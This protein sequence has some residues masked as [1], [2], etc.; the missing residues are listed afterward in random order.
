MRRLS[1]AGLAT[2]A[3]LG[4]GG[5][6]GGGGRPGDGTASGV[7]TT[8]ASA[9]GQASAWLTATPTTTAPARRRRPRPSPTAALLAHRLERDFALAGRASGAYV[10]DITS[11]AQLFAL[12]ATVRRPPASVNKL[13]TSV[14][15]LR[16][17][18]PGLRLHTTVLGTGHL[19]GGGVWRGNLYL[20]GGGD[21][22]L[23]DGGFNR[24][25]EDGYGPT[26]S[27]LA[28][29]LVRHGIRRV[30]GRLYGDASLFDARRGPPSS[31]FAPDI[32]DLGG[33][34][35]A[36]TFDHGSTGP[37][38][39]ASS[40]G[41]S[42][43]GT[44]SPGASAGGTHRRPAPPLSPGAFAA[45]QLAATLRD[46]HVQVTA[47]RRT[48][49]SPGRARRLAI[50]SSPPMS[51]MLRLMDVPSDDFFAEM[52]TKQLGVRIMGH[53]T[54]A[55]GAFVVRS[56]I[57]ADY[58]LHPAIV[59]GSG[60]S[61]KDL[62]SPLE[63]VDLLRELHDTPT[64]AVLDASLPTVGID[65]T[66]QTIGLHTAAVGRCIAKTGT[67]NNVTNLA[68]YCHSRGHHLL[69]FAL[70]ID[71]PPNW[72]ALTLINRMVAAVATY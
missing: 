36:L 65:G 70:F 58:N 50:V 22:T 44:S 54:T 66:V 2:I 52:L 40:S 20:R 45:H 13:F 48:L 7:G 42:S 21:P 35:S 17:L 33:Q 68:G 43:A 30:T 37:A 38:P 27:Q 63:V 31:G 60:L 3:A 32:P 4:F 25:W 55:D 28:S 62:A 23:G 16:D 19:R 72:T 9:P 53:G 5:C 12:R 34:L 56:A 14:A 69:A 24:V 47:S 8:T 10:Y 15:V 51:V 29:Q 18:G 57:A 6:G 26:A 46:L 39:S 11:G 64:G 71:G 1:V 67:L 41:T 61:R 59:D 49:P